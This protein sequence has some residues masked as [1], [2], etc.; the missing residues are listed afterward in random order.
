MQKYTSVKDLKNHR[1]T[2][3]QGHTAVNACGGWQCETN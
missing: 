1:H 2:Y 3:E